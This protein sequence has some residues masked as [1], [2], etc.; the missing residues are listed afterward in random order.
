MAVSSES[1][2]ERIGVMLVGLGAL[3]STLVAGV[4]AIVRGKARPIGS[5]TQLYRCNGD[6]NN[7]LLNE[8][9]PMA[10][11]QNL[12]FAAWDIFPDSAY[13]SAVKAAVLK[14]DILE[15]LRSRLEELKPFKAVVDDK[16]SRLLTGRHVK[17]GTRLEQSQELEREILA[18]K[19]A[20]GLKR[21]VLVLCNST[22]ITQLMGEEAES[23]Q[24]FENGLKNNIDTIS[25]SMIYAY[26]AI[27]LGMPVIN[28]TPSQCL[29]VPALARFAEEK[30]VPVSGKDLKTGQTLL[31]TILAPGIKARYL[32]LTGWYSTNIL[33][34]RDGE[35]LDDPDASKTKINSKLSVLESILEPERHPEL[36]RGFYHKVK[37]DYYPPRGDNKEAW[38]NVDIFGWMDYPMQIK[39]NFLCRDSILAA[40]L[41]LDL[42][43]LI[44]LAARTGWKGV[45]NW[46]G[47]FFKSPLQSHQ[48]KPIHDLFQQHGK[49][50]EALK[51]LRKA[52]PPATPKRV[53]VAASH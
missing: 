53:A 1:P 27:K 18:F 34:N 22:E 50:E 31:K 36:Y 37:I 25:A 5:L 33:G 28:C 26:V 3:A 32:G 21:M 17:S 46:L 6:A 44:D 35:V 45:Q 48:T 13:Q 10:R 4:E 23:I 9:L 8:V 14:P 38:D 12:E 52:S 11:L 30:G 19:E 20:R 47:F 7:A 49:L 40:P 29:E 42:V 43:L 24:N 2:Q 51:L 39:V 41:V 15:S 16:N